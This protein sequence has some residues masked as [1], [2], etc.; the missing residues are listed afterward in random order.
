MDASIR[1]NARELGLIGCLSDL[2]KTSY[3]RL[4]DKIEY[5]II[6]D[7][8]NLC[9]NF[10]NIVFSIAS[11]SLDKS[12][13]EELTEFYDVQY[14]SNELW[15]CCDYHKARKADNISSPNTTMQK[16]EKAFSQYNDPEFAK[17]LSG[18]AISKKRTG[19]L[20]EQAILHY[21]LKIKE[22]LGDPKLENQHKSF[23]NDQDDLLHILRELTTMRLT[24]ID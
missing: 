20:L 2:M 11:E 7:R 16:I 22:D 24:I 1:F 17:K 23:K 6:I 13:F 5:T 4:V 18:L 12:A 21:L 8:E 19:I 3:D 10:E 9:K 15:N 14:L